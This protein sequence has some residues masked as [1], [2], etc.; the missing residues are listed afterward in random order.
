MWQLPSYYMFCVCTYVP[1]DCQVQCSITCWQPE[2]VHTYVRTFCRA[3]RVKCT[4][5][6]TVCIYVS[7]SALANLVDWH[8][9]LTQQY[10]RTPT[11]VEESA[12]SVEHCKR[13]YKHKRRVLSTA[14]LYVHW[15]SVAHV[16]EVE[17]QHGDGWS[18]Y[19]C[20]DPHRSTYS[21]CV[22]SRHV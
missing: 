22:V 17:D 9:L 10:L 21:V 19:A 4:Y 7:V 3:R 16:D 15:P 13:Q 14:L 11:A 18:I 6:L 20:G 2:Y 5:V 1:K 12:I 8:C